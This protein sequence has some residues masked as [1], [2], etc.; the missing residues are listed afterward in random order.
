MEDRT[1]S[2]Q[3]RSSRD[4]FI[5]GVQF[6]AALL[7]AQQVAGK[8]ARDGLFLLYYGPQSLPQMVAGAAGFSVALSLLTGRVLRRVAPRVVVPW[9]LGVSGAL[10]VVEWWLL[11]V[12]PG[13]ASV[14]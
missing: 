2:R 3:P 14:L 5:L 6:A 11:S 10:L 13:L 12:N 8:A 1:Q 4:L 9:S 7:M